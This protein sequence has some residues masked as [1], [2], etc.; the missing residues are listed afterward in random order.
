MLSLK[1]EILRK[2]EEVNKEKLLNKA[3]A[4][5]GI[6][7]G[8][9]LEI[10]NKGINDR[11]KNDVWE[12]DDLLKKSRSALEAKA[13]LYEKLAKGGSNREQDARYLVQFRK[14]NNDLPPSDSEEEDYDRYPEEEE[15]ER[16]L[17]DDYEA[18]TNPDEEWYVKNRLCKRYIYFLFLGW[19]ML[20]V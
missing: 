5:R 1:A 18:P 17:S 2:Q 10:K 9:P 16:H 11:Q 15:E 6:K 3:K 20:I 14:K 13:L 4:A 8:S 19:N 12:D 7:K